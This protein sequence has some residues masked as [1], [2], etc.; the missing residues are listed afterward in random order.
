AQWYQEYGFA[1]MNAKMAG[2]NDINAH[3]QARSVAD[4]GRPAAGSA[5]FTRLWDSVRLKPIYQNGGLFLDKSDLYVAEG[6]YNFSSLLNDAVELLAGGNW[7]RFVLNS[8]KTL[9]H[10]VDGP[11]HINELG[12]YLQV[13]KELFNNRLKLTAAG[14]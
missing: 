10:E 6:Q 2:L 13:G 8:E 4:I 5:E 7:R 1:Y 11:I 14:R 9:F 12:A 3:N